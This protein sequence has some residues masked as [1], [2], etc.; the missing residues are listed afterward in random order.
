MD[1]VKSIVASFASGRGDGAVRHLYALEACGSVE[2]GY[3]GINAACEGRYGEAYLTYVQR[4]FFIRLVDLGFRW[5]WLFHLWQEAD[6]IGSYGRG[7]AHDGGLIFCRVGLANVLDLRWINGRG[8]LSVEARLLSP[9][10]RVAADVRR[11]IR[12]K[13]GVANRLLTSAV[14]RLYLAP[15]TGFRAFRCK[16]RKAR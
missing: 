8:V 10:F 1:G 14:T 15:P 5:V 3:I 7:I 9:E 11:R 6:L 16:S 2:K 13:S 12:A 4:Q